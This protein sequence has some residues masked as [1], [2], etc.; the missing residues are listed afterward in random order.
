MARAGMPTPRNMRID[1][2]DDI[3]PA[4]EHVGFP[5]VIKPVSGGGSSRV[6]AA[7]HLCNARAFSQA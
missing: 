7:G 4:G 5:A 3:E 1:C 6:G 2:P